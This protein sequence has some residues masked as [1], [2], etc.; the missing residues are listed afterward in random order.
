MTYD[1]TKFWGTFSYADLPQT[2]RF[3]YL[4]RYRDRIAS[5]KAKI[6]A[7]PDLC[8]RFM[9]AGMFLSYRSAVHAGAQLDT[10]APET[11][12]DRYTDHAVRAFFEVTEQA[13]TSNAQYLALIGYKPYLWSLTGTDR[14]LARFVTRAPLCPGK[15]AEAKMIHALGWFHQPG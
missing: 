6:L 4:V 9:L 2:R 8:Y 15:E 7:S 10:T 14:A 12:G 11:R 3:S 13:I 5:N 1:K